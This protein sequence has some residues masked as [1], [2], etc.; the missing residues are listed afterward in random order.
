MRPSYLIGAIIL[1]ACSGVPGAFMSRRSSFGQ[2]IA[3]ALAVVGSAL[4]VAAAFFCLAG[5]GAS[6]FEF[7]GPLGGTS[8]HFRLDP[9]SAFFL[10]PIFVL[11]ACGSVFGERYWRQRE[12]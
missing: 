6:Q 5:G 11:G 9:L 7:R 1:L 2:H 4:G 10:V 3:T 12:H 8:L